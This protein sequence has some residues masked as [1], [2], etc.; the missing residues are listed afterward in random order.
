MIGV[1]VALLVG[2]VVAMRQL[3]DPSAVAGSRTRTRL[4]RLRHDGYTSMHRRSLP[5]TGEIIDHLVIGPTGIYAVTSRQWDP[6]FPARVRPVDGT[7]YHGPASQ[8][9]DLHRACAN[10]AVAAALISAQSGASVDV[11]A[12]LAVYGAKLF[13]DGVPMSGAVRLQGVDV[14]ASRQTRRW[15]RAQPAVLSAGDVQRLAAAAESALPA[16]P[17]RRSARVQGKTDETHASPQA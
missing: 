7:V 1:T 11:Q 10:A 12:G 4:S 8:A 16:Q 13:R 15:L 17:D 2:A 3:R 9:P 14:F 6:R 5:G